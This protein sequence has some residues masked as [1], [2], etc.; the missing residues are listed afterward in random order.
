[1]P[2]LTCGMLARRVTARAVLAVVMFGT[3]TAFATDRYVAQVVKLTHLAVILPERKDARGPSGFEGLWTPTVKEVEAAEA[4][5]LPG[6]RRF[7]QDGDSH[8][9]PTFVV[10]YYGVVWEKKK[11]IV[12]R[13]IDTRVFIR[14][15]KTEASDEFD[16]QLEHLLTMPMDSA[17]DPLFFSAMYDPAADALL[18]SWGDVT[19]GNDERLH[20]KRREKK[21]DSQRSDRK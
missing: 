15:A 20:N 11:R 5:L 13:A 9:K 12:C 3:V 2:R 14:T 21:D 16:P 6:I 18:E 17:D 4:A 1:M 7:E 8:T 10:Q 19:R